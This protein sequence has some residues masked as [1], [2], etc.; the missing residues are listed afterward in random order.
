MNLKCAL[1]F[2]NWSGCKCSQCEKTRDEAHSWVGC[3]CSK[4]GKTQDKGHDWSKDCDRC[5]WCGKTRDEGH[6]WSKDCAR[7]AR[8]SKTKTV[9][10]PW[11]GCKCAKCAKTRDECHTWQG[12]KCVICGETRDEGHSWV[13]DCEKCSSCGKIRIK[14]HDWNTDSGKCSKCGLPVVE[15][16]EVL[17]KRL[18]LGTVTLIQG[19]ANAELTITEITN[20]TI[21]VV[22]MARTATIKLMAPWIVA[23]DRG[24][25]RTPSIG[26]IKVIPKSYSKPVP[27]ILTGLGGSPG[28]TFLP[29][30]C[31]ATFLEEYEGPVSNFGN[32]D[33]FILV[34]AFPATLACSEIDKI[35]LVNPER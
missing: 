30:G 6:D 3:K 8:C 32:P 1:G 22:R 15:V 20:L 23:I 31:T 26:V 10:H 17:E 14:A 13:Q 2:H 27:A 33:S 4:C 28:D 7:C 25:G 29:S 18:F 9:V 5:K 21:A 35:L 12:C 16:L 24:G 19:D 11:S 34:V